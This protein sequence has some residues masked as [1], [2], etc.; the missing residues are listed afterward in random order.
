MKCLPRP[1]P[2]NLIGREKLKTSWDF[3]KSVL[4]EYKPDTDIL[5]EDCFEFDW[6]CTKIPKII[7]GEEEVAKCKEYLKSVYK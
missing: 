4:R 6:S 3:F 7:K 1:A 5:L 2:I